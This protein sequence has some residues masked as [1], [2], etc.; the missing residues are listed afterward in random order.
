M[1]TASAQATI[2]QI[3]PTA[4]NMDIFASKKCKKCYGRGYITIS[5]PVVGGFE[6]NNF[7]CDCVDKSVR[8][9]NKAINEIPSESI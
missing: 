1:D 6:S 4:E 5:R 2:K 8:K 9:F 7:F 3:Q